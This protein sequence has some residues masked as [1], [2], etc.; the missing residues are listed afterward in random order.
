[1]HGH[2]VFR[3][4]A[5]Q[6]FPLFVL[7]SPVAEIRPKLP[8]QNG[9][10]HPFEDLNYWLLTCH[11]TSTTELI[12]PEKQLWNSSTHILAFRFGLLQAL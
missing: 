2:F 8:L 5:K 1:L 11:Q 10:S 3:P 9:A 6:S 7:N 4:K 12:P